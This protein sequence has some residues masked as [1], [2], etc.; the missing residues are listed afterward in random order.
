MRLVLDTTVVVGESLRRRGAERFRDGRL[1]L[2]MPADT[3]EEVA[4]EMRRRVWAVAIL[5]GLTS[6]ERELA[7]TRSLDV[8]RST[9]NV[10]ARPTYTP[11]EQVARP[12][13]AARFG[14]LAA[15]RLRDRAPGGHLDER[16]RPVRDR[17]HHM[18]D[19]CAPELARLETGDGTRPY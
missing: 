9:V 17:R 4:V 16:P 6:A 10:V 13:D 15:G 5:R 12:P 18:G 14:R 7:V 1:E 8:I 3:H 2:F 19:R 11:L